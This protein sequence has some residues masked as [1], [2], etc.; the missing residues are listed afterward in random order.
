MIF[1][2]LLL[3]YIRAQNMVVIISRS[4][5]SHFNSWICLTLALIPSTT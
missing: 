4:M 3:R 2:E 1:A 5:L